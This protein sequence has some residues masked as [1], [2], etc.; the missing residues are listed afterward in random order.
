VFVFWCYYLPQQL[1]VAFRKSTVFSDQKC[2]NIFSKAIQRP[3]KPGISLDT[4][5]L[6]RGQRY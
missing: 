3:K 1:L 4:G 2:Q 5:F 6:L